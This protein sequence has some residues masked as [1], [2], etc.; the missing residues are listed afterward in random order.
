MRLGIVR[1][2]VV[3]NVAVPALRG[4]RLLIVDPV[5]A[6]NLAAGNGLGGGKPLVAADQLGAGSG[7]MVAFVEGREAANPFWP[8]RVPVDAYCALLVESVDFRPPDEL[9]R[10]GVKK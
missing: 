6:P 5:T 2:R 7:Q 9:S 4:L 1:G 8:D 10:D 3:L